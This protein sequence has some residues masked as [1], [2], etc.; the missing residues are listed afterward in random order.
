[1]PRMRLGRATGKLPRVYD[2]RAWWSIFQASTGSLP[3]REKQLLFA[4]VLCKY[5]RRRRARVRHLLCTLSAG[6][7]GQRSGYGRGTAVASL[8]A[9]RIRP[10]GLRWATLGA[11]PM[12][13]NPR[14]GAM[15]SLPAKVP[16][17]PGPA[18][19]GPPYGAH[20]TSL[21]HGERSL[22]LQFGRGFFRGF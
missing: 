18:L 9:R 12:A 15:R 22:P 1:M 3:Q 7:T 20:L 6:R 16:I 19:L 17:D 21:R 2:F 14:T 4:S 13:R 10:A 8:S 5:G 11:C